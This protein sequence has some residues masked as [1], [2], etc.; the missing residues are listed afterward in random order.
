MPEPK[1]GVRAGRV[2]IP[3]VNH[4]L[5]GGH[6][7]SQLKGDD[8]AGCSR[9][10][11]GASIMRNEAKMISAKTSVGQN[12]HWYLDGF[13]IL[14]LLA[15]RHP[16][17]L[18]CYSFSL[19]TLML[20]LAGNAKPAATSM[21]LTMPDGTGHAGCERHRGARLYRREC[22]DARRSL[23]TDQHSGTDPPARRPLC[24]RSGRR[25]GSARRRLAGRSPSSGSRRC[26]RRSPPLPYVLGGV[27]GNRQR[28]GTIGI[29]LQAV[30]Q[31]LASKCPS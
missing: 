9:I 25:D 10:W 28:L 11:S 7:P 12:N 24:S 19:D 26:P 13:R 27:A 6:R 18:N 29:L 23:S 8:A 3:R 14:G 2:G 22:C 20:T 21:A 17:S 4:C 1:V 5:A 15:A 16:C 31:P 30:N